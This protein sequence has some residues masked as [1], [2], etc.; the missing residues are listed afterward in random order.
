MNGTTNQTEV[1]TPAERE[2]RI[3]RVF[4]AERKRVFEAFIDPELIPE[5]WGA[6]D[7][8][9]TVEEMDVRPGGRW[10]YVCR[11]PEGED[12]FYGVYREVSAP[13]RLVYT[14]EFGGMPGHV[15]IEEVAFEDLGD[16]T[17]VVSTSLFHTPEE[18]D[19]MLASGMEGGLNETYERLDALL[20]RDE[21]PT[22]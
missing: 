16:R 3:E 2:I 14:F 11:G 4:E 5:W 15:A 20:A 9:T 6:R 17:K 7:D 21:A 19:G 13:E 8:T 1:T 22:D 18:R 10:R 12:A